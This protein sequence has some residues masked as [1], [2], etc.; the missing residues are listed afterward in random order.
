KEVG[1]ADDRE[2]AKFWEIWHKGE[3]R[4]VWV[5]QG[6]EDILDEADPHLKLQDF[7]PCPCPAY[8]CVQRGSLVPVPDIMQYRDQLDEVNLL[9]GRIHALSDAVEAKGFYPSGG[10]ELSEAIQA[11]MKIKEPGRILV[12]ISDWAAF[13][14]TKDVIVWLPIAEISQTINT[15]VELRKQVIED[16][17]QI[18]GL[19]DIMR[20]ATDARETL[21]AQ[22]L[23]AQYGSTRI[24]D[25]QLE[26][27]RIARDLVHITSQII[28]QEFADDTII[29]MAQSQLPTED[30]QQKAVMGIQQQMQ[31]ITQQ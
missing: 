17:Y 1:G 25:K 28:T 16:I 24:K 7:F 23:K 11:A 9:T 18:M 3:R 26:M 21:G 15:L 14:G 13:G 27:A 19:S 8:G 22:N 20:G 10:A 29:E 4:V 12:P 30:M 6:C 5:A 31:Q 2:R